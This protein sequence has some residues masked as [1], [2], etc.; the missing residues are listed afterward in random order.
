[1][2]EKKKP[3]L[4]DMRHWL[5]KNKRID[6]DHEGGFSVS[7]NAQAAEKAKWSTP[8]RSLSLTIRKIW[9]S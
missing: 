4:D 3:S 5:K 9:K 7:E 6:I 1:M 2:I 8:M